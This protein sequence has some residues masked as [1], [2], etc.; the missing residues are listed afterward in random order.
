[1]QTF[2]QPGDMLTL[3][4]PAGGVVSGNAYLI[5]AGIFGV[6]AYSAD[7]GADFEMKTTGV[8]DLPKTSA[9]AVAAGD[10]LY[11]DNTAKELN[12]TSAGNTLVGVAVA[13]AANPSA[14][15]RIKLILA[16]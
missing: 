1:M 6:A 13:A 16:A 4:A 12:K 3:T 2:V 14:V 9:L 11:W 15:V 5:G 10:L 7:A 8:F